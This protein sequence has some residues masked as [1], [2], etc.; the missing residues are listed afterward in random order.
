MRTKT[1]GI[2]A[3]MLVIA[4]AFLAIAG[5][6]G[7]RKVDIHTPALV[8]Q[9]SATHLSAGQLRESKDV[10]PQAIIDFKGG[11]TLFYQRPFTPDESWS[12]HTSD[13]DPGYRCYENF[14]DLAGPICD[15]HWWGVCAFQPG[16]GWIP[17]T[18][19]GMVFN[20]KF[21]SD[22][23]TDHD[24]MP[25]SDVF[26]TYT[27]VTPTYTYYDNY[28]GF[29]CYYF[30]FDLDPCCDLRD[31]W[32]SIQSTYSS[33][34]DSCWLLWS[35]SPQGDGF[36]YQEFGDPPVLENDLAIVLTGEPEEEWLNHKMHFP[37]LPDLEGWDVNA[38]Y[39]K[40]LADDWQ[41]SRS[42][43]IEDIHFWGSWKDLDGAPWTDDFPPWPPYFWLSIHRNIP[44]DIDTP[45][46][47]PGE[48]LWGWEGEIPGI[49]YEPPA[50]EHWF[51][52]NTGEYFCNDHIPYWRYDFFFDQAYP[53]PDSFYQH[54][55]S[56]YWLNITY[57]PYEP[58]PPCQWGWKSSRDHF[59]DDAVYTDEDP[60]GPWYPM[61]EPPRC[62]WFDVYF[63]SLGVP[64]DME[65][66]NYYGSG[67]YKYEYWW[68]M[69][70][71]D[72]P[73][74]YE[75]P[76]Y[77]WL[78]FYISEVGPQ[79]FAQFA[80]NWS[81]DIWSM[82]GVPG[83]PPLP[84]EDEELYIG[85]QIF[86]VLPGWNYIDYEIPYYNPEWVSIDF[87]AQDVIINGW[88][89][90]ECHPTS[91]D[92]A[93][94]ITG[95]EEQ[96]QFMRGDAK[97]DGAYTLGDGLSILNYYIYGAPTPGCLDALDYNDDGNITMGDGLSCLQYYIYGTPLPAAPGI[98]CGPDPTTDDPYDC[99]CHSYCMGCKGVVTSQPSVSTEGAPNRIVVEEAKISD[100]LVRVPVDLTLSEEISGFGF[101]V[102]YDASSLRFKQVI[103]GEGDDFY[104]F[105]EANGVVKLGCVPDLEL[106]DMLAVGEHR[107]AELVFE[108]VDKDAGVA[109]DLADVEVYNSSIEAMPVEWVVKTG[110]NLPSEFALSQNYP[111]P[112]N[113]TTL[114]KYDLLVDCR[115]RLDVYNVVGQRVATLVDEKQ[116]AGYKVARWD[117]GSFSSGIYF[118]RLQAG[119]Y[120]QTRKMVLIR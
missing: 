55:D 66:T 54:K 50:M 26:C 25:P 106:K 22:D 39:P 21:Y 94:V 103:G 88:I 11:D 102:G 92:L 56:I 30:S 24:N 85:R 49:P 38:T 17:C 83:R 79:P 105:N 10:N 77:I 42:G 84:G 46:S 3:C 63:D 73:F 44:A 60:F 120:V 43:P 86:E 9:S 113:S 28:S 32:V 112:F 71:Y 34:S 23:P 82:E 48:L 75:R 45:W 51:Y 101:S 6:E 8:E 12:F 59:M 47:R 67:W 76:K 2:F 118:Y 1:A 98:T 20:I 35:G 109:F 52:P 15:I 27:N 107:V 31:G 87:V 16:T 70:F 69:W 40:I 108:V 36:A 99:V 91:M 53:P 114:I 81:T 78:D 19:Q 116:K 96:A 37:Q 13:E 104:A 18:P 119:D 74:T 14:W 58:E 7:L 100:G 80:I 65:S 97:T 5:T 110:A 93:F 33:P 64:H 62:N 117:A 57:F 61:Y 41:C 90:H 29:D 115:V 95:G 111:N 68:N 4:A 72:N 89:W